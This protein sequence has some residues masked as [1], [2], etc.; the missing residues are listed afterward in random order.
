MPGLGAAPVMPASGFLISW[1]SIS[2]MPIADFAAV[3]DDIALS[4]RPTISRFSNSTNTWSV[5]SARTAIWISHDTGLR[6][7]EPTSTAF[8]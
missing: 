4:M 8:T 5:R 6:V 1:A 2:A 3:F 7:S